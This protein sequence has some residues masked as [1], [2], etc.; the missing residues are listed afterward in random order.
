MYGTAV[1]FECLSFIK[2]AFT[3][4]DRYLGWASNHFVAPILEKDLNFK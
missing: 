3:V 1:S 2:L 4:W